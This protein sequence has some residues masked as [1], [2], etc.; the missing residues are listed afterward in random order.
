METF[1]NAPIIALSYFYDR[2][3]ALGLGPDF[4][5]R[6]LA[7]VAEKVCAGSTS[8]LSAEAKAELEERPEA[9]LDLTFM[10]GLLSL[11]YELHED[12]QVSIAK[13]LGGTEL[14]WCLG[15]QLAVLEEDGVLCKRV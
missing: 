5:I 15:A 3:S 12:R 11:G 6:D 9:C 13:K 1:K 14:G 10:H 7:A 8:D 2:L 4:R